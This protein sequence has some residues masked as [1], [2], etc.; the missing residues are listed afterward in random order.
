M[1]RLW[2]GGGKGGNWDEQERRGAY[3]AFEL[4]N[5]M[6]VGDSDTVCLLC[7]YGRMQSHTPGFSFGA[8]GTCETTLSQLVKR[9]GDATLER[10]G[11]YSWRS[12]G[13]GG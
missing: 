9:L 6:A 5:A 8:L 10:Q 11:N 1:R 12:V 13:D 7:G 2:D 3:R 4:S